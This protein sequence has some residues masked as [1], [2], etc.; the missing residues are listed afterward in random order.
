MAPLEDC[1]HIDRALFTEMC[2]P[3]EWDQVNEMQ[4][5]MN[6]RHERYAVDC[7][8][9]DA[10]A[11][12]LAPLLKPVFATQPTRESFCIWYGW[13]P[14]KPL[15]DMAFSMEANV[16][17]AAYTIWHDEADDDR[18]QAWITQRFRDLEPVSKGVYLGD[19]DLLRRP[20]KFMADENFARLEAI[21][22][23][24]DPTRMF[25]GFRVKPGTTVNEFERPA[26]SAG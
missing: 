23:V 17:L 21:R 12:E 1:P 5:L 25:P 19:A 15:Q 9:T 10:S 13:N 16:Y 22:E 6:P 26:P 2:L 7:A 4:E 20:G 11:T 24:Y 14:Q 8:W 3:V 18:C